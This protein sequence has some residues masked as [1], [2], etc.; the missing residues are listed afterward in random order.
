MKTKE[1]L[2]EYLRERYEQISLG[3]YEP[4]DFC[5]EYHDGLLWGLA[6]AIA[7]IDMNYHPD[8][9]EFFGN[10]WELCGRYECEGCKQ[11]DYCDLQLALYKKKGE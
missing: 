11:E 6:K 4:P 7:I 1:E 5:D 2:M 9:Y 10:K 8:E 3:G